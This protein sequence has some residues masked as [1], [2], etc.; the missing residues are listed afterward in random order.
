MLLWD[1]S[2]LFLLFHIDL[3]VTDLWTDS[4]S[5]QVGSYPRRPS[6]GQGRGYGFG[7]SH[8]EETDEIRYASGKS[9]KECSRIA[10]AG[11]WESAF[12]IE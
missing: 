7:E 6:Q 9:D 8:G 3:Y 12:E 10:D 5:G 11:N 4:H 1:V 2:F